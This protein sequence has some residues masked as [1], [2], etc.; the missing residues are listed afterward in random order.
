MEYTPEEIA[1]NMKKS[2]Q[3]DTAMR[4][5]LQKFNFSGAT[6]GFATHS[7]R[8][9]LISNADSKISKYLEKNPD[10]KLPSGEINFIIRGEKGSNTVALMSGAA[11]DRIDLSELFGLNSSFTIPSIL[12]KEEQEDTV[13]IEAGPTL[14]IR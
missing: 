3:V 9:A 13:N 7:D 10:Y 5:L 14:P 11:S 12:K 6:L 1:E 2:E 4:N 8:L